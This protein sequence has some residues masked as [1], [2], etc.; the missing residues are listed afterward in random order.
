MCSY[1]NPPFQGIDLIATDISDSI[2]IELESLLIATIWKTFL[3]FSF[4]FFVFEV[5]DL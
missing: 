1:Y 4:F 2:I 5:K 3:F